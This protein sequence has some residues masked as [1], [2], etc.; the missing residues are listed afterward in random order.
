MSK[1]DK[2]TPEVDVAL[3]AVGT[4]AC[5][6]F[7]CESVAVTNHKFTGPSKGEIALTVPS[8]EEKLTKE[9]ESALATAATELLRR[10]DAVV[11]TV[12]RTDA[13][14]QVGALRPPLFPPSRESVFLYTTSLGEVSRVST[15]YLP[16]GSDLPDAEAVC[17]AAGEISIVKTKF[18]VKK[19]SLEV[20]FTISRGDASAAT[21]GSGKT[22][23]TGKNKS[24]SS[25][26]RRAPKSLLDTFTQ[27]VLDACQETNETL[28]ERAVRDLL[29]QMQNEC[30]TKGFLAG[31][32]QR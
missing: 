14:Q 13:E 6:V 10:C 28:R 23:A 8:L 4:A 24:A 16:D 31:Q 21:N 3:Q 32:Q 7:A 25:Q 12:S 9:Q 22:G 5:V 29:T 2:S 15:S 20:S 1:K 19:K 17:C 30:F 11:R 26:S 27:H 18:K